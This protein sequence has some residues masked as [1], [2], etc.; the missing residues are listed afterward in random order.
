MKLY[1]ESRIDLFFASIFLLLATAYIV[2]TWNH[3]LAGMATDNSIYLLTAKHFSPWSPS[4]DIA[5]HFAQ[6]SQYPPLYPIIL[7]LFGGGESMLAAHLITTLSLLLSFLILRKW[8]LT[9]G[10]SRLTANT[11][12]LLFALLPGTVKL[13]MFILS[14]NQYL[15]FTL[16]ALTA[17]A[18]YEK[19]C[20][21]RYLFIA[22]FM[23][24]GATLTRTVG[25]TLIAAFVLYLV[26]R[27]PR[28]A[29]LLGILAASPV[30]ILL[31]LKISGTA[32][33]GTGY[34]EAFVT[35]YRENPVS[36]LAAQVTV[37]S[38]GLWKGW[39]ANFE[40]AALSF[41]FTFFIIICLLGLVIGLYQQRLD[42]Y[43]LFFYFIIILVWP[44][45]AE[46]KRLIYAIMP[47]L[48]GQGIL[49]MHHLSSLITVRRLVQPAAIFLSVL[50]L[51]SL[52]G[53]VFMAGRFI[54]PVSSDL[55]NFKRNKYFYLPNH[56]TAIWQTRNAKVLVE[57]L[58]SLDSRLPTD[59]II[60]GTNPPFIS[61][62][63][64]R[65]SLRPPKPN[66][67][68]DAFLDKASASGIAYFYMTGT[69]SPSVKTPYYPLKLIRNRLEIINIAKPYEA[70]N[71]PVV[72]ILAR[73][74]N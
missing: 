61:Y 4:S 1:S 48:F 73:V 24:I 52:P 11:A 37:E 23:I 30:L 16:L 32:D 18:L 20:R 12:V 19:S 74:K 41:L 51:V 25:I 57:D 33:Q 68:W 7:G 14:E 64:N 9:F 8:L 40:P 10:L 59:A 72:A 15:L 28:R 5:R 49:L 62:H 31:L 42:S 54:Q 39:L 29:I 50:L 13:S 36:Q 69:T 70:E 66:S 43:Y 65:Q 34:L 55:I 21:N 44:Y 56:N 3:E 60:Y 38:N 6:H 67:D 63:S 27:R 53:T 17:T 2:W 22:A 47:I 71:A 58:R 46:A 45:P 26:H 35:H